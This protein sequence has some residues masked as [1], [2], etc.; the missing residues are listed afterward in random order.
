MRRHKPIAAVVTGRL[1]ERFWE[2]VYRPA[3]DL[4]WLFV[5]GNNP[6]QYQSLD[7]IAAHRLSW[8]LANGTDPGRLLV[9]HSCDTPHC[10]NPAHLWL[11]TDTDNRRDAQQ[12][13]RRRGRGPLLLGKGDALRSD[14]AF[15]AASE[16]IR[17]KLRARSIGNLSAHM[18]RGFGRAST[19]H[20]GRKSSR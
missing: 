13:G 11:G 7:G 19:S 10:V 20:H 9:C 14:S 3:P 8:F 17:A 1:I 2:R 12:K 15:I 16:Q 4:C 18:G 5:G 6:R